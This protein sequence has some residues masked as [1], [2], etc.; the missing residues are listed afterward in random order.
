M[1]S[2]SLFTC[3]AEVARASRV[4]H[5]KQLRDAKKAESMLMRRLGGGAYGPA[6]NVAIISLSAAAS[7]LGAAA[8][9]LDMADGVTMPV[10]PPGFPAPLVAT[11]KAFRQDVLISLPPR[12]GQI[13]PAPGAAEGSAGAPG[14]AA[15]AGWIR[16]D[17][18]HTL[19]AVRGADVVVL[20]VDV[21]PTAL[22]ATAASLAAAEKMV[23]V[24][25]PLVSSGAATA[26]AAGARRGSAAGGAAIDDDAEGSSSV[27]GSELTRGAAS[28]AASVAVGAAATSGLVD[29]E[30]EL[31]LACLKASGVP[32]IVGLV[33]GLDAYSNAAKAGE[34]RKVAQRLFATEFG[35]DIARLVEASDPLVYAPP[36]AGA[37]SAVA[38][39]IAIAGSA[40][41][42]GSGLHL[43]R[44]VCSVAPRT[45]H[46]RSARSYM[47]AQGLHWEPNPAGAL[48][49]G[50]ETGAPAPAPDAG[51]LSVFG[52]LKGRPF[53]VHQLV[54]L[55]WGGAYQV[56]EVAA[57]RDC[58]RKPPHAA[59]LAH[60]AAVAA[61][62]AGVVA[63]KGPA[64]TGATGAHAHGGL[65]F[66]SPGTPFTPL[67]ATALPALPSIAA[68]TRLVSAAD[69]L[70]P[71]TAA[72]A[73]RAAGAAGAGM[74]GEEAAAAA[75]GSLLAAA[76]PE[77]RE[78]LE[79]VAPPEEDEDGEQNLAGFEEED[80][81]E[82]EGHDASSKAGARK[83]GKRR[84]A[85]MSRYQAS[86]LVEGEGEDEDSEAEEGAAEELDH[87]SGA[88]AGG[89]EDDSEEGEGGSGAEEEEEG[90]EDVYAEGA[91][92][93]KG[94][95]RGETA[96][97]GGAHTPLRGGKWTVGGGGLCVWFVLALWARRRV[98]WQFCSLLRL[99]RFNLFL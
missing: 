67:S 97:R 22:A 25:L 94:E 71:A 39:P 53:N 2:T 65:D 24:P 3:S 77:L 58:F 82:G 10:V 99:S 55:P 16:Y 35:E 80:E 9:L 48:A 70:M 41:T 4:N 88:A 76:R 49:G 14:A 86:W 72:A 79:A 40:R 30:G 38:V 81:E 29:A 61:A 33:Q 7:P 15:G 52:Y 89:M 26:G 50:D 28:G 91:L 6:R 36:A 66:G 1:L 11:Y 78:S 96:S 92:D 85:G 32:S 75:E 60:P 47:T 43:C 93:P 98:G 56:L 37:G 63:D 68:K 59:P 90:D 34:A 19:A 73:H 57:A 13:G 62:A 46:W 8:L 87:T 27:A 23:Q 42:S 51:T 54:T 64:S 21:S 20:V 69:L 44:A 45:V 12:G 31:F 83:G 84:P 95:G 18:T 17:V 74:D 5:A